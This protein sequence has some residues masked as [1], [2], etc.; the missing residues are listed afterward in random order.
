MSQ[1]MTTV[2]DVLIADGF[3]AGKAT[4]EQIDA[5]T[6]SE[7]IQDL[8]DLGLPLKRVQG[9][10][11]AQMVKELCTMANGNI[12]KPTPKPTPSKHDAVRADLK[13]KQ[14][15]EGKDSFAVLK[16]KY[17]KEP[18]PCECGCKTGKKPNMTAGG[19]YLPGHDSIHRAKLNGT[20]GK[21]APKPCKCGCKGPD[22][23]PAMTKGGSW[24][25]G[26]DAKHYSRLLQE[27]RADAA[28]KGGN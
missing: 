10:N 13:V 12:I 15:L 14:V 16:K 5:L 27:A 17:K 6:R 26:H 21:K 23:K 4:L 9:F 24:L 8:T 2:T 18:R 19:R 7:L 25:P 22:G 20:L 1:K 28:K 11:H 3:L